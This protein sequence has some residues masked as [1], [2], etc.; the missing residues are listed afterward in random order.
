MKKLI[1]VLILLFSID[2]IHRLLLLLP[3]TWF[4]S[5]VKDTVVEPV[6][7]VEKKQISGF[8]SEV[9][10]TVVETVVQV[11]KRQTGVLFERKVNGILGWNEYGN[12]DYHA[13]YELSLIHISEPT[14]RS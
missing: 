12:K 4:K 1:F 11:E 13:M 2:I 3:F 6:V 5:E 8:K 9:K 10:D 14:R 7:I